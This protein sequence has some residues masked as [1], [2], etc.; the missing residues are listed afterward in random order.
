MKLVTLLTLTMVVLSGS[1]FAQKNNGKK[2]KKSNSYSVIDNDYDQLPR[3]YTG[4]TI[5]NF[6]LSNG[7]NYNLGVQAAYRIDNLGQARINLLITPS[8]NDN[9]LFL[10][11]NELDLGFFKHLI[12]RQVE[13]NY[14][15]RLKTVQ[16]FTPG[17]PGNFAGMSTPSQVT[18]QV[19]TYQPVEGDAQ[20]H[21]GARAGIQLQNIIGQN[22]NLQQPWFMTNS[23]Q[24][25][26]YLGVGKTT[27]KR[28]FINHSEFGLK[29]KGSQNSYYF[30][31]LFAPIQSVSF[32]ANPIFDGLSGVNKPSYRRY[33]FGWRFGLESLLSGY[34]NRFT[35]LLT[36]EF[37]SRP[38]YLNSS[39]ELYVSFRFGIGW[40]FKGGKYGRYKSEKDE[41]Y[42]DDFES[43]KDKTE[44]SIRESK[45]EKKKLVKPK[46]KVYQKPKY[47]FG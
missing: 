17:M 5:G 1:I 35:T 7:F 45:S 14:K 20:V 19:T 16:W 23:N 26:I 4:L 18:H 29:G 41:N 6:E 42:Q 22:N 25:A 13:K 2:Q 47:R 39:P 12:S 15:V 37:G 27:L 31:V 9:N 36:A 33:P 44:G 40:G 32:M 43:P 28:I 38:S 30:D 11:R 10:K 21:F 3:L 34:R 24:A 8:G 46:P